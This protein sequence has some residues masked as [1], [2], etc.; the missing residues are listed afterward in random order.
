METHYRTIEAPDYGDWSRGSHDV[1][2]P[3]QSYPREHIP[4]SENEIAIEIVGKE[5]EDEEVFV[6][7]FVVSEV[8]DRTKR[9]FKKRLLFNLNLLMENVG[10]ADVFSSDATFDD[11]MKSLYVN[12]EILPPGQRDANIA[13]ILKA[14]R[15]T[16]ETRARIADRY[17]FLEG[18]KPEHFIQG[19]GGFK[20]YFGAQF[21][22]DLVVFENM[23]YGN[24]IYVMF[25]NWA[26]ESQKSRQQLLDSGREGK[27]FIRVPHRSRWKS[28][29]KEIIVK[30]RN[31]SKK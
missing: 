28:E 5:T 27:D 7:R 26:V 6:I 8:M 15:D 1:D 3:Y 14:V 2:L 20:R 21:S 31:G 25:A 18:L 16:P 22:D 13:K 11:Y 17:T 9:N 19:L 30:Y 29:V 24:A 10:A 12:W 23:E 4:P